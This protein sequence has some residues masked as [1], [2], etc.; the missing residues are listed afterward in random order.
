M[1]SSPPRRTGPSATASRNSPEA[2]LHLNIGPEEGPNRPF[3][4]RLTLSDAETAVDNWHLDNRRRLVAAAMLEALRE[5][6]LVDIEAGI[7]RLDG[8]HQIDRIQATG[9][10]VAQVNQAVA[11]IAGQG[12]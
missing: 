10:P 6:R 3:Y 1:F 5:T 11:G 9:N 2:T 4:P 12:G 8:D 7:E